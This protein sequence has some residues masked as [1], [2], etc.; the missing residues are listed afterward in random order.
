MIPAF[1]PAH[2]YGGTVEV[3][4]RLSK[5][6][7]RKGHEVTVYT[8]DAIDKYFRQKVKPSKFFK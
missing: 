6:L 5:E 7:V 1:Y 3:A 4:Y 8:N 2:S